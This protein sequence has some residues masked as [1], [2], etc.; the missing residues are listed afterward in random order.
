MSSRSARALA[1]IAVS[2]AVALA[3]IGAASPAGA[4]TKPSALLTHC[5]R[6]LLGVGRA[7]ATP[8]TG[9]ADS[10]LVSRFAIFRRTRSHADDLPA[11]ARLRPSLA[12]ANAM[13]YDPSA[14]VLLSRS[15]AQG[16]VYAV[17]ATMALPMLPAECTRLPRFAD[18]GAYLALQ[19]QET[20]SGPGACLVATRLEQVAPAGQSPPGAPPPRP[21]RTLT[22]AGAACGSE[23]IL[24][25]YRGTLGDGLLSPHT[26]LALIPDSISTI[27]YTR[28]NGRQFTVPVAGNVARVPAALSTLPPVREPGA[29]ELGRMLAAALPTTVTESGPGTA[30][31]TTLTRPAALIP[32]IVADVTF[33]RRALSS[34]GV[35]SASSTGTESVACSART[36]R[37]LAVTVTTT[38]DSRERCR[39]L[40]T[41][42]RYRYVGLRPPRGTVGAMT[43]PTAPIVARIDQRVVRPR[44]LTL[45]LSGAPRRRVI[46]VVSVSCFARN[47]AAS[48]GGPVLTLAVPSRTLLRLPGAA[49]S[50]Q[51]CDVSALVTST[52]RR[53]TVRV[54]VARG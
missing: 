27:T 54:T 23:A 37:C 36:H 9:S 53:G 26:R 38:C 45:V 15:G 47:S 48:G 22:V 31:A 8:V 24:S 33:L 51:A 10:V 35:S 28:A 32:D 50:F 14:A 21:A 29:A 39:T 40:R 25:G 30:P 5:A 2:G 12:F 3:I 42:Y 49:R 18:A 46:V 20:G 6:V 13:T 7:P 1:L 17:P 52:Q 43:L 44:K 4:T 19:A 34:L 11:V 41:I 16:S